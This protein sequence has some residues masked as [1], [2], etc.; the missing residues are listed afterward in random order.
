AGPAGSGAVPPQRGVGSCATA[1]RLRELCTAARGRGC[2]TAARREVSSG[3]GE[4]VLAGRDMQVAGESGTQPRG[5]AEPA[6]GCDGVDREVGALEKLL[7]APDPFADQ[8]L[9]GGAA[10]GLE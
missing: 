6:L 8:P 2:A 4:P 5:G 3:P 1:A 10:V 7:C 9:A